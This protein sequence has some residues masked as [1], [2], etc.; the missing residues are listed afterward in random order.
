MLLDNKLSTVNTNT[1]PLRLPVI[2]V[3]KI[4]K[5]QSEFSYPPQSI[6]RVIELRINSVNR[7]TDESLQSST[8]SLGRRYKR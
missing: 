4:Q 3:K 8:I 7:N 2:V 5:S 6:T 1:N